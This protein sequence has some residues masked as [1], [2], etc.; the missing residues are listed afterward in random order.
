MQ[1]GKKFLG[2]ELGG[3]R[4][5]R[6]TMVELEYFPSSE[7]IF[8]RALHADFLTTK[9]KQSDQILI[10]K[11]NEINPQALGVNASL[12]LPPCL[13]CQLPQCPQFQF[14]EVDAVRWMREEAHREGLELFPYVQRPVDLLLRGRWRADLAHI[15][16]ETMGAGRAP[17]S[18]RM[19]YLQRHLICKNRVEVFPRLALKGL[20]AQFSI[21]S[22]ELRLARDVESGVENRYLIL[23]KISQEPKEKTLPYLFLYNNDLV[24]FAKDLASFDA[25]LCS[26]MAAYLDLGLLEDCEFDPSWGWVARPKHAFLEQ[27]MEDHGADE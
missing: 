12:S 23:E 24:L 7:K 13:A 1:S 8:F 25:L 4:G 10:D 22:R 20:A 11:I 26:L 18:S 19:Q 9:T 5:N 15:P 16:D 3:G 14:C 27:E 2:V 6:T 21:S 17:L